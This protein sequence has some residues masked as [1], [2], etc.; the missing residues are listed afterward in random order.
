[1]SG[2]DREVEREE[3]DER[4][5]RKQSPTEPE[6]RDRSSGRQLPVNDDLKLSSSREVNGDVG[7]ES[8]TN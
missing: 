7:A 2:Q 5:Q 1:M 8:S 6:A 3:E 4:G